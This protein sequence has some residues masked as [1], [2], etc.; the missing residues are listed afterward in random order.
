MINIGQIAN[1]YF[2]GQEVVVHYEDGTK[3]VGYIT[4]DQRLCAA[5][6]QNPYFWFYEPNHYVKD[7]FEGLIKSYK[8][9]PKTRRFYL[10]QI[11]KV[12]PETKEI[13]VDN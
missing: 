4:Y 9:I 7:R 2:I 10:N 8:R 1:G 6:I 11:I 5:Q 13:W 3:Q 12:C